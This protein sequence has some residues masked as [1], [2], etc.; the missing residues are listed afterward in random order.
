[1]FR[2]KWPRRIISDNG[3]EV[4]IESHGMII[5]IENNKLLNVDSEFLANNAGIA[6]YKNSIKAWNKPNDN[7]I[8]NPDERDEILKNII[9]ALSFKNINAEID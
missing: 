6:I 7:E 5:Y 2:K 8:I 3:F 4:R 1:M 9:D